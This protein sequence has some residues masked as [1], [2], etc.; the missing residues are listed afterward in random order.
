MMDAYLPEGVTELSVDSI[1]MM[2]QLGVLSKVHPEAATQVFLKDCLIRLGTCV[3]PVG[4]AKEGKTVLKANVKMPDGKALDLNL[5]YGDLKVIPLEVGKEA[6]L[7]LHPAGG[8]D[9][10][11]G[12]KKPLKRKIQGGVVGIIFDCRGRQPFEVPKDKNKRI[13][14]LQTWIDAMDI[15]PRTGVLAK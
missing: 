12:K 7:D 11:E 15:Y 10:G 14:K 8:I 1:F 4:R 6:E 2:P 9:V 3:A 13:E 5:K